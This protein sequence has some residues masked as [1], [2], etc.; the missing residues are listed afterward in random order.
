MSVVVT[1]EGFKAL[2][3]ALGELPKT[4]ARN[5]LKRTLAKAGEPIAEDARRMVPVE[6]GDLRDSISV[7][8]TVKNKAGSAEFAAAMRAGLGKDA[9][10]SAMRD[11]RRAAGPQYFA[12]MFV[13]PSTPLGFHAHFVEFGTANMPAHPFMRPAW[14]AGKS[15][16]LSTIRSELGNQ[17]I[18]AARRIARSK[19]Y[20]ADVKYQASMA[21]L[22]AHEAG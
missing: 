5:V 20:G 21:A 8:P 9:A 17:I 15:G 18:A 13:G 19:R 16:A 14:D 7:S 2:D 3:A 4:I 11:A 1:I 22:M 12:E 10:V 6:S